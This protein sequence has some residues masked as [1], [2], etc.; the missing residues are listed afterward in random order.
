MVSN[1]IQP[2]ELNGFK[3]RATPVFLS[4]IKFLN[5]VR[6][7]SSEMFGTAL[8]SFYSVCLV[9][10]PLS[11]VDFVLIQTSAAFHMKIVLFLCEL[12]FIYIYIKKH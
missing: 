1:L 8:R 7:G 11:G 5:L 3:R 10:L 2:A 9:T 4:G 6:H 12:V